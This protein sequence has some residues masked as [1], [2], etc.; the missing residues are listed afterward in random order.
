MSSITRLWSV[1]YKEEVIRIGV[2][3]RD[4]V[5]LHEALD[6]TIAELKDR[7]H[8]TGGAIVA[9]WNFDPNEPIAATYKSRKV[10]RRVILECPFTTNE[11]DA[12]FDLRR[13]VGRAPD[14]DIMSQG[15]AY[16]LGS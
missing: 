6:V 14:R 13:G 5:A 10:L 1:D 3:L 7:R 16:H 9:H 4:V 15:N 2:H 12:H 11:R 8:H